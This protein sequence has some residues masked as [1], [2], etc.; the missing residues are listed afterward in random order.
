MQVPTIPFN[1][2]TQDFYFTIV[3]PC[4]YLC[5]SRSVYALKLHKVL[6]DFTEHVASLGV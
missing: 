5:L 1:H 3:I 2:E 4:I 6:S